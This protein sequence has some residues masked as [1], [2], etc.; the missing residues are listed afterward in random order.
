MPLRRRRRGRALRWNAADLVKEVR[1]RLQPA[2]RL[3]DAEHHACMAHTAL[4][5]LQHGLALA[6]QLLPAV[7]WPLDTLQRKLRRAFALARAGAADA[8]VVDEAASAQSCGALLRPLGLLLLGRLSD[9]LQ[10][11]T[12]DADD[13]HALGALLELYCRLV[14][15]PR[16]LL[17]AMRVDDAPW[18]AALADADAAAAAARASQQSAA[19][20]EVEEAAA[21]EDAEDDD[22][23]IN[24]FDEERAAGWLQTRA[25]FCNPFGEEGGALLDDADADDDAPAAA[26]DGDGDDDDDDLPPLRRATTSR[27][28]AARPS[29]SSCGGRRSRRRGAPRRPTPSPRATRRRRGRATATPPPRRRP[30]SAALR[31]AGGE[32]AGPRARGS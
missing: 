7:A 23:G 9:A 11:C 13:V 25:S 27:R 19:A 6:P 14:G 22:D 16:A 1:R 15:S 10:L 8:R 20:A 31:T 3:G 12:D 5:Q 4:C 17:N 32:C 26:D 24:P 2:L 29:T 18:H 30:S 21:A 28:R